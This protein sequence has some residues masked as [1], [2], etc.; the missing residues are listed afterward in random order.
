LCPLKFAL[1]VVP[2]E[3][4]SVSYDME[5]P[6]FRSHDVLGGP[7][8]DQVYDVMAARA[9]D[10]LATKLAGVFFKPGTPRATIPSDEGT[11]DTDSDDDDSDTDDDEAP[12]KHGTD[13]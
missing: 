3:H 9:F 5:N 10:Q 7:S 6:A 12:A 8:D 1:E 13:L 4:F 11:E 2:P